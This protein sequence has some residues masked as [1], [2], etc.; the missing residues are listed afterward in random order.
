VSGSVWTALGEVVFRVK[1]RGMGRNGGKGRGVN[2][3]HL[4]VVISAVDLLD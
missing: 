2:Y 1:E 3:S 4:G